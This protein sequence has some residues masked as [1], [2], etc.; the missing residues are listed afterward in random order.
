MVDLGELQKIHSA[1]VKLLA[2]RF[3]RRVSL[4][5]QY[6]ESCRQVAAADIALNSIKQQIIDAA[7]DLTA[8]V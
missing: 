2:K 7:N 8:K 4:R 1:S 5:K 6:D 3:A